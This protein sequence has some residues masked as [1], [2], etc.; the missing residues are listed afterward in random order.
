MGR[1]E[2]Q[3]LTYEE[4]SQGFSVLDT[5]RALFEETL[6]EEGEDYQVGEEGVEA[7]FGLEGGAAE[8]LRRRGESRTASTKGG[9]GIAIEERGATGFG[10]A[11]QR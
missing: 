5:Q 3:N 6:G 7:V 2:Q 11:G 9:G 4:V 10:S 8:K 1:L